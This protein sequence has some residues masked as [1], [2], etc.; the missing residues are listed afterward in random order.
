[1]I[2]TKLL[3]CPKCHLQ[4][5]EAMWEWKDAHLVANPEQEWA[6]GCLACGHDGPARDTEHKAIAAWN[7][8]AETYQKA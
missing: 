7:A 5:C 4:E 1:M 2:H 6:V 8:Y 3:P